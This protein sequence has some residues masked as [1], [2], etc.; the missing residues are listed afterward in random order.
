MASRPPLRALLVVVLLAGLGWHVRARSQPD[1]DL[2]AADRLLLSVSGPIQNALGQALASVGGVFDGYLLLVG[3]EAENQ[4]LNLQLQ[5][6]AADA[7]ELEELRHQNDRLRSLVGLRERVP[8]ETV[9]ASII[10]RGTSPR[11]RT[12]RIDKG[13]ADGVQPGMS[14]VVP[15]GGVGQVLRSSAGYSDVLLLSDGLSA[16][17]AVFEESRLGGVLLGDGGGDLKLGFVRRRDLGSVEVGAQLVSSGEDGVFP[18]GVALG[19]V[20]S[21]E[22]PETGLFLNIRVEPAVDA[23]RIEEVL[24]VLDR[25]EGPFHRATPPVAPDAVGLLVGP[26][27]P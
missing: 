16:A 21:V 13:D 20:V 14:V 15:E 19:T 22:T 4:R 8:G 11:F 18:E 27:A 2:G 25:G 7:R 5:E 26:P 17:G 9:A 24:V 12:L 6:A 1:A 3:T 10:G 23:R